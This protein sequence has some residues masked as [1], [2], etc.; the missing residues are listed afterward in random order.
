MTS[1]DNQSPGD[2]D[3]LVSI[4]CDYL[5]A[6]T[7]TPE[8]GE[9]LHYQ[10]STLFRV[11][12]DFGN[13]S[14]P[15]GMHGF[16]GYACGSTQVGTR[17][18]EVIVRLSSDSAA[19]SWRQVVQAAENVSR[20]DLQATVKTTD[21]AADV[22][23]SHRTEASI[24]ADEHKGKRKVRWTQEHHGGYTLYLGDRQSNVFGRIYD[25]WQESKMVQ[26][27]G[28][29]RFEAQF[30]N[31]L[32]WFIANSLLAS[33]CP[34]PAVA[35]YLTQFFAGRGVKLELPE[36]DSATY[37]CPR[38]RSDDDKSLE[39]LKAAVSPTVKRLIDSGRGEEVLSALG[40]VQ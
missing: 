16:S 20:I 13:K 7:K 10:G 2:S 12:R 24:N 37:S 26:Y 5:T 25:K 27:T 6:T 29:V 4:G 38:P 18:G 22:I 36:R 39:W 34:K 31:K 40:L 21:E 28:C 32:A 1:A 33:A 15:W 14:K 11:Q 23:D 9:R 35:S 3:V 19:R 8:A 30:Q 17:N